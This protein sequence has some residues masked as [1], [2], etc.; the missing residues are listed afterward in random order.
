VSA[1]AQFEPALN[2]AT[3]GGELPIAAYLALAA[4][5]GYRWIELDSRQAPE[6][7][8]LGAD[9]AAALL[10]QHGLQI[11]SFFL[12]VDWR[13]DEGRFDIDM[14][15]LANLASFFAALGAR[16]CCTFLFPNQ[17]APPADTRRLIGRRFARIDAVLAAHGLRFG[18]EFLGPAHF[19]TDP[20]HTFLYRM[21]DMLAFAEEIGP[22]VGIL[23]DSLHWY[24][25]GADRAALAAVPATRL[26][27]AHI[28]DAPPG[29]I[30]AQ[31]DDDRVLPGEGA[32]DLVGFI[33]ALAAAGYRGPIG[34][35]ID[36][37]YLRSDPPQVAARRAL[38]A[39][40]ALFARPQLSAFASG[41]AA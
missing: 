17:P 35:E 3:A 2:P 12:P 22:N 11:A 31:R 4:A 8:A 19:L 7:F 18:L 40:Q 38:T 9:R 23:V 32:I 6:L 41:G 34:I 21:Q 30:A 28:D 39:W 25:Q 27:Y 26:V 36:G 5:T 14:Q 16:R 10:R 1:A 29:P 15:R 13:H 33:Q 24:C 37:A 20:G